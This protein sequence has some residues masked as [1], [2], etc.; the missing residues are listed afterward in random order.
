VSVQLVNK[1][2]PDSISGITNAIWMCTV[3]R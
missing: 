2:E 3:W 1:P